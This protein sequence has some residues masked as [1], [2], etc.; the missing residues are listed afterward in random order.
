M[1]S[2]SRGAIPEVTFDVKTVSG[3]ETVAVMYP[4]SVMVLLPAALVAVSVTV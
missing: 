4:A 1:N 2:T 3:T